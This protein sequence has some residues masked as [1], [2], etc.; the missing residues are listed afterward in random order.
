[1]RA[2]G[3]GDR[4]VDYVVV[5]DAVEP[6][7]AAADRNNVLRYGVAAGDKSPSYGRFCPH[8]PPPRAAITIRTP[9]DRSAI[10]IRR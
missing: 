6:V 4:S 7:L 2:G 9:T 5:S 10:S 1:M 8:L 3:V